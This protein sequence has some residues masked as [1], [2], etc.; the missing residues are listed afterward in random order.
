MAQCIA[1]ARDGDGGVGESVGGPMR[2]T[3]HPQERSPQ[4]C[5]GP[6]A[7]IPTG[8]LRM[9]G[10]TMSGAPPIMSIIGAGNAVGDER[11]ASGDDDHHHAL[12]GGF[13]DGMV[14]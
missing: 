13:R 6:S 14:C 12:T 7:T 11:Q 5:A 10:P 2:G 1:R 4:G 3:S 8:P 9:F